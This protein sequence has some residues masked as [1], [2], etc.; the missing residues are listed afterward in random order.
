MNS[1]SLTPPKTCLRC[2]SLCEYD[3]SSGEYLSSFTDGFGHMCKADKTLR[4]I[5]FG[6]KDRLEA[7]LESAIIGRDYWKKQCDKILAA[8]HPSL[9]DIE[10]LADK[11][12]QKL[13]SGLVEIY[14]ER[15]KT[16]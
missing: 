15:Q 5:F 11:K 14:N 2:G 10:E 12:M 13:L 1:S 6:Q 16:K 8:E 7:D 3:P 9:Y 4:C